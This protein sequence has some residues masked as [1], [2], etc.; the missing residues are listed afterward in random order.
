MKN[1]Q[2]YELQVANMK[3]RTGGW[4]LTFERLHDLK[5][6]VGPIK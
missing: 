2:N 4:H 5:F 6:S 1:A 3:L